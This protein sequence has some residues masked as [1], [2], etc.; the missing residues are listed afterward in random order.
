ML[1]VGLTIEIN[2]NCDKL[3]C[4]NQDDSSGTETKKLPFL[5]LVNIIADMRIEQHIAAVIVAL[6]H[7]RKSYKYHYHLARFLL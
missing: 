3:V 1:I 7:E 6:F 5:Q 4:H 2:F